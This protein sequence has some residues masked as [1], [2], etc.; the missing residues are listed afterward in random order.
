MNLQNALNVIHVLCEKNHCYKDAMQESLLGGIYD[1]ADAC[2]RTI[3]EFEF[4]HR[5]KA[6]SEIELIKDAAEGLQ[7][8][9][10]PTF[11][12]TAALKAMANPQSDEPV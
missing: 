5:K 11:P 1:V 12:W 8:R 9:D 4:R 6:E 3:Q 2:I 10:F 7:L